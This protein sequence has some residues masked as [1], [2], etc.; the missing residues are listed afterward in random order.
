M[1]RPGGQAAAAR[2]HTAS[3]RMPDPSQALLGRSACHHAQPPRWGCA[4]AVSPP[5]RHEMALRFPHE[6]ELQ[7]TQ[8]PTLEV[9]VWK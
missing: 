6:R 4:A 2:V 1:R 8:S 7:H 3:V 5:H 9:G